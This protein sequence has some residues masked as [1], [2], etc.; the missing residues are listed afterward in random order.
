[1]DLF[2]S[3]QPVPFEVF[4]NRRTDEQEILNKELSQGFR[5]ICFVHS[6]CASVSYLVQTLCEAPAG[7]NPGNN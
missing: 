2:F 7:L 3:S 4:F 1:M 6:L 5:K